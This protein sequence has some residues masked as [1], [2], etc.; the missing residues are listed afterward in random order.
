M[1]TPEREPR[2]LL[3]VITTTDYGG[4]ENFLHRLLAGLDRERF[5]PVVCSLCPVGWVGERI[6][7][8]GIPV[9]S[10]EM[11]ATARPLELA[12]G[13]WRLA[14]I[15]RERRIELVQSLLYRANLLAALASRL[16]RRRPRVVSG[17]RSLEPMKARAAAF[18]VRRTRRFAERVV[19]VSEAVKRE[20]VESEG[21]EPERVVVIPN[22][23][24]AE[25]FRPADGSAWRREW[26]I[27]DGALT[28]GAVGRLASAK[29]LGYLLEAMA[30]LAGE[31]RDLRLVMVGSGP[32]RERLEARARELG[33]GGRVIFSGF[34]SE[35]ETVYPAFDLYALPSLAE[36]SPNALLEAL[37][38]GCPAVA[39]AV[40]G[41]PEIVE[42]GHSGLLVPPADAAAL[43]R[44]LEGLAADEGL[45]RRLGTAGRR[46]IEDRFTLERMIRTHEELY[47]ALIEN[48]APVREVSWSEGAE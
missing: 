46:R 15:L 45:R 40:G 8:L 5:A 29:G 37:A 3:F 14:R 47:E 41:V 11:S 28:I 6:A 13:V 44:A 1:T 2:R 9:E 12:S 22:G 4:T 30:R 33:L 43:A 39:S 34:C 35:L 48:R 27:P 7:E 20:L 19:A 10:L 18:A 31:G 42:D 26:G 24:D 36:G 32:E 17:Q 23:I 38:C 16:A 25:L 21:L